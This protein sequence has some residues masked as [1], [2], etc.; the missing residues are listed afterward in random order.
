MTKILVTGSNGQ[1]GKSLKDISQMYPNISF[2]W[3]DLEELDISNDLEVIKLFSNVKPEYCINCAA[4][5]EVDNAEKE[6]EKAFLINAKSVKCWLSDN[7]QFVLPEVVRQALPQDRQAVIRLK[8]T[9]NSSY[10]SGDA[11]LLVSQSSYP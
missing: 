7:G 5:T 4:Y 10:N 11:E 2:I 9:R 8:R 1:L 3:T 6:S